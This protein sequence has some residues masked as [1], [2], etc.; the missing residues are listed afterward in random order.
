VGFI[1]GVYAASATID[2]TRAV[3]QARS[4]SPIRFEA[5]NELAQ[6]VVGRCAL[7]A[8]WRPEFC[9][10]NAIERARATAAAFGDRRIIAMSLGGSAGGARE[11]HHCDERGASLPP[12]LG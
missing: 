11:K 1:A 2:M 4:T 12:E 5:T 8:A 9:D 6:S 10:A 3:I 7:Q